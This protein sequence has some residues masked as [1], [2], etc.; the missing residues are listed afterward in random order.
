MLEAND[1]GALRDPHHHQNHPN[2]A[3]T[4]LYEV[5]ADVVE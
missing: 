4:K 3:E 5:P 1:V 2:F